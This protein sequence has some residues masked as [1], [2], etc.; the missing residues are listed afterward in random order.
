MSATI[1][2]SGTWTTITSMDTTAA[3]KDR[4][5]VPSIENLNFESLK[6]ATGEGLIM[7]EVNQFI[8]LMADGYNIGY[9]HAA[10][11]LDIYMRMQLNQGNA[12]DVMR[13]STG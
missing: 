10:Q 1:S 11:L 4:Q 13:V 2:S 7:P 6:V 9:W 5:N 8:Q 12:P 3:G